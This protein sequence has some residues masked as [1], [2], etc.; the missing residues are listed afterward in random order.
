MQ[1]KYYDILSSLLA[2][3][4][5]L[6]VSLFCFNFEYKS[7][8]SIVYLAIAFF[9][10]YLINA[11]G[12]FLEPFYYWTIGGKPSNKILVKK[13]GK[14]Y[15]GIRKVKFYDT[16]EVVSKLKQELNDKNASNEKMFSKAK[17]SVIGNA[18]SRVP[19]FNAHY[20]LSRTILTTMLVSVFMMI[21]WQP[22]NW[23]VYLM[24]IPLLICWNRYRERG[25]Y[26]AR[27]VLY[28]YLKN[29][30]K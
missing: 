29:S 11:L 25:Y 4:I 9:L 19:D 21:I 10:G 1:F 6:V 24:F 15:S 27:E 3:Y 7:E 18:E 28:E 30:R 5:A 2:G 20:A 13:K 26:Y 17:I 8:Y 12:S 23:E 16:N 14:D 22:C